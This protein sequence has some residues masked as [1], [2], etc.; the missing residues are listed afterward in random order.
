MDGMGDDFILPKKPEVI[1]PALE[2]YSG[3]LEGWVK[4]VKGVR[5]RL[6]KHGRVFHPEVN[7]LYRR[8]EIRLTQQERRERLDRAVNMALRKRII[9]DAV[10]EK[11]RYAN[12]C[13]QAWKLR[14]DHMLKTASQQ[15]AT[16]KVSVEEREGLLK[17][18]W[19]HI[20]EEI[21]NG[22]LPKL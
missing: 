5:D 11:K 21:A 6:P 19:L 22:E 1:K 13:T 8:I 12:R 14:R 3:D 15:C 16:G 17:E 10:E 9:S 7:E 18:F 2:F 4:F 20:D